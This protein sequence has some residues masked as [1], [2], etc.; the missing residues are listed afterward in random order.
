[1]LASGPYTCPED[2]TVIIFMERIF[3]NIGIAVNN[4][5]LYSWKMMRVLSVLTIYLTFW[6]AVCNAASYQNEGRDFG[7]HPAPNSIPTEIY[8]IPSQENALA[9]KLGNKPFGDQEKQFLFCLLFV[10]S[11]WTSHFKTEY[12]RSMSILDWICFLWKS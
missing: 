12:L 7:A 10:F 11:S 5:T 9:I 8:F 6:K 2:L 3:D 1:M 4:N